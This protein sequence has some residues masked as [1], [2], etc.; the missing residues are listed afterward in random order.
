MFITDVRICSKCLM[1]N[2]GEEYVD[3]EGTYEG[4]TVAQVTSE[5]VPIP[6]FVIDDLILCE[7][8]LREA[9]ALIG[10]GDV[11][12][13]AAELEALRA[14]VLELRKARV[15]AERRLEAIERAFEGRAKPAPK[16]A[17]SPRRKASTASKNG[18]SDDS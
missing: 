14:E 11:S 1:T 3:L 7:S 2:V 4:P 8:C 13:S 17:T 18:A 12:E 16:K 10:L 5:G 9:A 6:P 15:E